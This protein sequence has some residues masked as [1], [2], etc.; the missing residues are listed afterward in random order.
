MKFV[1]RSRWYC[2]AYRYT[3]IFQIGDQSKVQYEQ[4]VV[5]ELAAPISWMSLRLFPP[6]SKGEEC[7]TIIESQ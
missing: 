2:T 5:K 6:P 1:S 4:G 7:V 3:S